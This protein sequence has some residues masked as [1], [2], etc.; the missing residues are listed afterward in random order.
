[1]FVEKVFFA[2]N[3]SGRHIVIFLIEKI[4]NIIIEFHQQAS[5]RKSFSSFLYT[6]TESVMNDRLLSSPGN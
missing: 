4:Q 6:E 2:T 3:C 1:M 5:K